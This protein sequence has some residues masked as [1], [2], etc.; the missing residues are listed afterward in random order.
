MKRYI[1]ALVAAA[2]LAAA[3]IVPTGAAANNCAPYEGVSG[4]A[5][6]ESSPYG[7]MQ[8]GNN[9]ALRFGP[10]GRIAIPGQAGDH[11]NES[12]AVSDYSTGGS[13]GI[14]SPPAAT[15]D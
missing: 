13:G 9:T 4:A 11:A 12:A 7:S 1:A 15:C 8:N 5:A 6:F 14:V 2:A 3:F 10:G